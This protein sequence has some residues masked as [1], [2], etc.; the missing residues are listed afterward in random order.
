MQPQKLLPTT[1]EK[2]GNFSRGIPPPEELQQPAVAD[3]FRK[4]LTQKDL[5]DCRDT[6]EF[7]HRR[8]WIH[9]EMFERELEVCYIF[10]SPLHAAY[11]SWKLVPY[12]V[13]CPYATV[14][15]M[16]FSIIKQFDP[17]QLSSPSRIGTAFLDQPPEARYQQ[18]FYSGLFKATGGGV[19]VSPE[20]F[21]VSGSSSGRTE[22]FLPGKKWG[23][24]LIQDGGEMEEHGS[25]FEL[26]GKYSAWLSS[27][28]MVDHILLDCRTTRPQKAHQSKV[29]SIVLDCLTD[30][31]FSDVPN[32]FHVVLEEEFTQVTIVD[33]GLEVVG[34]TFSLTA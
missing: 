5:S 23:I 6:V 14:Q 4:L 18:G 7:C 28:G 20:F 8:G 13:E 25:R 15:E 10:P 16:C 24:E 34:E 3:V 31:Y 22:F 21:S 19:I 29:P 26:R 12:G 2:L 11:V 9:S 32:L 33:N 27:N 1:L 17:S 30:I